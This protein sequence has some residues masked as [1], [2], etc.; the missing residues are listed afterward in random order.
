MSATG[1]GAAARSI[2]DPGA[3]PFHGRTV[4]RLDPDL[5]IASVFG[6]SQRWRDDD[7]VE[8]I[9]LVRPAV[10][11][12]QVTHGGRTLACCSRDALL[13]A[14]SR[15]AVFDAMGV[16]RI[17]VL[18]IK[19]ARLTGPL[20]A[21]DAGF[22]RKI[23]RDHPGLQTLTVYAAGL[24]QG[25]IPVATAGLADL[26]REHLAQLLAF[27]V[28]EPGQEADAP[29][30]SRRALRIQALKA[31]VERRLGSPDLSLE[32]V[33]QARRISSRQVQAM[34]Q[35]EGETFSGFVLARRLDQAMQ[36][37]TDT[38][39]IRPVSAIAFDVGFGDLSYFNRTFRKRF[40]LTPSQVR[41]TCRPVV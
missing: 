40:D 32:T 8:R 4:I 12:L 13:V 3:F 22:L 2:E 26:V 31:E 7:P 21:L 5:G 30:M 28:R 10:G 25:L 15:G 1:D 29:G 34:F 18:A 9:L 17:D 36:R 38:E 20:A 19:R 37:L 14:A 24:L 16:E 33:A 39:D 23:G 11:R 27:I 35:A 41:R 6:P